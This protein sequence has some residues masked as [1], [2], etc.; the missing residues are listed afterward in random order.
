MP[1]RLRFAQALQHRRQAAHDRLQGLYQ[2]R[3]FVDGD[4]VL[5]AGGTKTHFEFFRLGVPADRDPRPTSVAELRTA[6]GSCPLLWLDTGDPRQLLGEH[7]LFQGKLFVMGQVL[8]AAAAATAGMGAR[9]WPAQIAGAEHPL[10]TGFHH[11]AVGAQY[12]R[13]DLFARQCTN[14]EPGTP[15]KEGD[16]AAIV[17]QALD[18]QALFFSNGDLRRPAPARRLE[19]QA[20]D[21]LSHQLGASKMPVDR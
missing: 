5:A 11:F 4:Y 16:A 12:S 6:Q 15:L 14:D 20:S 9:R 18:G 17:G 1:Q 2:H 10:G 19:A 21:W 3:A 8:H 7:A 13:L